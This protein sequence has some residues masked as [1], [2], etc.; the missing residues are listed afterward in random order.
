MIV[1]KLINLIS[2]IYVINN[3]DLSFNK[4][5]IILMSQNELKK[6]NLDK[7]ILN[8]IEKENKDIIIEDNN[9]I[10]QLTSTFNQNN[11]NNTNNISTINLGIC[12]TKLKLYYNISNNTSLLILKMDLYAKGL[13]I[14]IIECK[15]YNIKTKEELDLNI[16][17]NRYK[18]TS[19]YR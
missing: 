6:E 14:P 5:D 7:F 18:Y 3:Y 10:Y 2:I 15:V 9:I 11:N 1:L 12:E 16:C 8:I 17:K 19:K 13:L 4:N